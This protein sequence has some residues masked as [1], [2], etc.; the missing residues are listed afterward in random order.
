MTLGRIFAKPK[1]PIPKNQKTHAVYSIPCSDCGKEYLDESKRL[2]GTCLKEHQE[3]VS[4]LNKVKSALRSM[5]CD[6][7]SVIDKLSGLKTLNIIKETKIYRH[8]W[9]ER[10]KISITAKLRKK[11]YK[12]EILYGQV[13]EHPFPLKMGVDLTCAKNTIIYEMSKLAWP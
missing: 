3:A 12:M 5:C 2:F 1:G 9:K 11:Y 10:A 6:T 8:S 13:I 4:T 7:K